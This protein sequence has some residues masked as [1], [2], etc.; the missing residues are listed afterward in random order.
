MD[1]S[2]ALDT[3]INIAIALAAGTSLGLSLVSGYVRNRLWTAQSTICV[4]LGIVAG[5]SLLDVFSLGELPTGR[6][7]VLEEAA[8]FMLGFSIMAATL[9]LPRGYVVR[10]LRSLAIVLGPGMIAMWAA[11]AA[12]AVGLLELPLPVAL[13]L[14][15]AVVP[16]DPVV[17]GAVVN[18]ALAD[19]S[20]PDRLRN[21]LTAESSANDGLA[22]LFV[23]LP[24]LLLQRPAPAALAEWLTGVLLWDIG[25]SV[26][27]GMAAGW[28]A[29]RLHRWAEHQPFNRS[30]SPLA[31]A[32]T[33][34]AVVVCLV[35]LAGSDGLFAVFAAGVVFNRFLAEDAGCRRQIQEVS[36]R[37]L[38]PPMFLLLGALLPWTDWTGLGWR[39]AAF[40]V[41]LLLLRRLP[42]WL[43][44]KPAI[45][46]F[47]SS[48]EAAFLGWF[49]PI[50]IST[51]YYLVLA[52]RET[53]QY[54]V[55]HSGSLAVLL[56]IVVYGASA[57]PLT[58]RMRKGTAARASQ[59]AASGAGRERAET[60]TANADARRAGRP[61]VRR[62]PA[63]L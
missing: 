41:A 20:V 12:L 6:F 60:P 43:L 54:E 50:G 59:P 44:L 8:R 27:V 5:P 23:M 53:Q 48:S 21:L 39:G 61:P 18:G 62:G 45:R 19:A 56:S 25:T 17:A 46:E 35:H 26:L 37:L 34:A 51:V 4:V 55:W 22:L 24:L 58:R 42:W 13:L 36:G 32:L 49:G 15:A 3:S 2:S 47:H 11:S 40:A 9:R 28:L 63:P 29:G 31:I 14:G 52:Q 10:R 38:E 16:T 7:L 57:T 1:A 30:Y 33:L